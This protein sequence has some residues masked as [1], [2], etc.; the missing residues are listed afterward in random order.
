[1]RALVSV[2]A[3]FGWVVRERTTRLVSTLSLSD[4]GCHGKF[5]LPSCSLLQE[6]LDVQGKRKRLAATVKGISQLLGQSRSTDQL[7]RTHQMRLRFFEMITT[8]ND[9]VSLLPEQ[10]REEMIL[11]YFLL[12]FS[13][14]RSKIYYLP[15]STSQ[16]LQSHQKLLYGSMSMLVDGPGNGA[17]ST[18]EQW[19][20]KLIACW[21]LLTSLGNSDLKGS[22]RELSNNVWKSCF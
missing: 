8:A 15:T 13:P 10:D 9:T 1:M 19:R 11:R 22:S 14:F 2:W 17:K 4:R 5:G 16:D 6:A 3:R 18:S 21:A 7:L 20:K 12:M